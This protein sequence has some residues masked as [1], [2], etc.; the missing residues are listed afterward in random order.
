MALGLGKCGNPMSVKVLLYALVVYNI[1][2]R[3]SPFRK[4]IFDLTFSS[5]MTIAY[6]NFNLVVG[7]KILLDIMSD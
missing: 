2:L 4:M 3:L 1:F 6:C 5:A 7:C